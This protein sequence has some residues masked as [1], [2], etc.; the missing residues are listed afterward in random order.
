MS[1]LIRVNTL[2]IR[3]KFIQGLKSWQDICKY[4]ANLI[5][6]LQI[7]WGAVETIFICFSEVFRTVCNGVYLGLTFDYKEREEKETG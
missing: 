2:C 7:V 5:E 3:M 6:E 1:G 4:Y